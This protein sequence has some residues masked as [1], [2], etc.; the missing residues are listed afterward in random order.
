MAV[1][2][3]RS[4]AVPVGATAVL[5]TQHSALS[6]GLRFV[7]RKPLGAAGGLLIAV[8]I[9]IAAAAPLA[10]YDPLA[11]NSRERLQAPSAS[12]WFGTD[13]SGRD[14]LS[15]V[16]W[17]ARTSLQVGLIAVVIGTVGGTVIG[18]VSG[19]LGG[20]VDMAVQRVMD[21]LMAFPGLVLAMVIAAMFGRSLWLVMTAIGIVIIPGT[22]RVMRGAVLAVL[23]NQFIEAARLVGATDGRI[24]L[25]HILPNV[26][27]SMLILAT[28]GLGNAI[29]VEASLSFVGLGTPPPQP[30]WGGMLSGAGR[31]YFETAPWMAVAPGVAITLA[32]LGFNLLGDA[33]RDVWDPRLRGSR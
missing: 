25:R 12:H 13:E 8:L 16:V 26:L 19:Y 22:N 10:P 6:T 21:S 5:S 4:T 15:R 18:L 31:L 20:K 7:R 30:S 23:P 1:S 3:D 29:L 11:Q 14:I 27:P 9:A 28:A 24:L 33:L 17:G 32:V 2:S